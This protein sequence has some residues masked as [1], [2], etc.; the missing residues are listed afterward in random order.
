[1]NVKF[2]SFTLMHASS[3]S[4][5]A[6]V[7]FVKIQLA[8]EMA[9][10]LP[11]FADANRD[12]L[13]VVACA[14][15]VTQHRDRCVALSVVFGAR[16]PVILGLGGFLTLGAGSGLS[17]AVSETLIVATHC[18]RRSLRRSPLSSAGLYRMR[19]APRD[20][21]PDRATK[22]SIEGPNSVALDAGNICVI[23]WERSANLPSYSVTSAAYSLM[24]ATTKFPLWAALAKAAVRPGAAPKSPSL[25][26]ARICG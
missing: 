7:N 11:G 2:G 19:A 26:R 25:R 4:L 9:V 16:G 5:F 6:G 10:S 3:D 20:Q 15:V 14:K 21:S 24:N 8:S 13:P 1:M 18:S 17:L 12:R 23:S 22:Q